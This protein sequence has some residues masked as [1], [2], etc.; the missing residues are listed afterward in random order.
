MNGEWWSA[1][2][3]LPLPHEMQLWYKQAVYLG[4]LRD[5]LM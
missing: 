2:P 5:I 3:P 4:I 1:L